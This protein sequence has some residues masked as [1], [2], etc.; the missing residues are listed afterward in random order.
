MLDFP[1]SALDGNVQ[2]LF[3]IQLAHVIEFVFILKRLTN[4]RCMSILIL[5]RFTLLQIMIPL[6]FTFV[7]NIKYTK[8]YIATN[9]SYLV[10]IDADHVW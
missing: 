2:L 9:L 1:S 5:L 4:S 6:L 10:H 8:F 3:S 7:N